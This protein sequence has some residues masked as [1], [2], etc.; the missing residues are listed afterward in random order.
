MQSQ[1]SSICMPMRMDST[2]ELPWLQIKWQDFYIP[3][4]SSW[5]TEG[6]PVLGLGVGSLLEVL[7]S[8]F[9]VL[10]TGQWASHKNM[11]KPEILWFQFS[12]PESE[13]LVLEPSSLASS[14]FS[15]WFWCILKFES[16]WTNAIFQKKD[17]SWVLSSQ[18]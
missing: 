13:T 11:L 7:D 1:P 9:I 16:H 17:E 2:R 5:T 15:E 8:C 14:K 4:H 18:S 12:S 10:L 3:S 6:E